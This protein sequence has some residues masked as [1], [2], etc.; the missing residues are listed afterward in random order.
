[1]LGLHLTQCRLG[2]GLPPYQV[3]FWCIQP[4]SHNRHGLFG[5]GAGSPSN[6]KSPGPAYL[7]TKWQW[8]LNP[9]SRL[10]TT[11]MGRKLEGAVPCVPFGGGAGSFVR[12]F[13]SGRSPAC[14]GLQRL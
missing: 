4:F 8:H 12:S 10:A 14:S 5:R 9:S 1:M 7:H 11:D 2:W 3:V 6:T 13:F